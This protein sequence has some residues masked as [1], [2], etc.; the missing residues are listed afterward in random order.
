MNLLGYML[1]KQSW[2]D[3]ALM[4]KLLQTMLQ[5]FTGQIPSVFGEEDEE[6][7]ESEGEEEAENKK[8]LVFKDMDGK[9]WQISELPEE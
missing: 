5:N 7:E 6:K 8:M 4:N 9:L 1:S 3:D 2:Q